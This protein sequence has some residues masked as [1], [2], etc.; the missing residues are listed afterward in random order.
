MFKMSLEFVPII[1][2]PLISSRYSVLSTQAYWPHDPKAG[3]VR[4][5]DKHCLSTKSLFQDKP[6]EVPE[7]LFSLLLLLLPSGTLSKPYYQRFPFGWASYLVFA[8]C[9]S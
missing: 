5:G 2:F 1:S 8:L 6:E 7:Q 3:E 9:F 4:E